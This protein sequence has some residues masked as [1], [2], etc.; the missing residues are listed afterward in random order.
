MY[1]LFSCLQNHEGC[2]S[3][4]NNSIAVRTPFKQ[5]V[6]HRATA[7]VLEA[8]RHFMPAINDEAYQSASRDGGIRSRCST[9]FLMSQ[10]ASTF[11][12]HPRRVPSAHLDCRG[13]TCCLIIMTSLW[14][15]GWEEMYPWYNLWSNLSDITNLVCLRSCV[16]REW[17][18]LY[19]YV[20]NTNSAIWLTIYYYQFHVGW[21][22]CAWNWNWE[23]LY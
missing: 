18:V 20:R 15:H 23:G 5:H 21:R 16:L 10:W 14:F 9:L 1:V 3:V 12:F 19:A 4:C 2:C 17:M 13:Q 7:W 22:A 8:D 6:C 11:R